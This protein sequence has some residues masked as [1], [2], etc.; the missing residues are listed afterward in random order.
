MMKKLMLISIV[1][2]MMLVPAMA[3]GASVE[4]TIQGLTCVT[5]GKVCPIGQE[6]PLVAAETT[7]VVHVMGSEFYLV[8]NLDRAIMARHIGEMVKVDGVMS[9]KY[10]A[11]TAQTLYVKMAGNW[12][13]VWN[14]KMQADIW[15][16]LREVK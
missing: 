14:R 4:G 6:D 8:P 1:F 7:F 16:D 15:N 11:I 2:V 5:Q 12:Q 3:I 10:K 13:T 9:D